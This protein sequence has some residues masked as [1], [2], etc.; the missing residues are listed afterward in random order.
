MVV[1]LAD[2]QFGKI[3]LKIE[4]FQHD[5]DISFPQVQINQRPAEFSL[6][7]PA[8]ILEINY[9][10]ARES[11]GYCGITTQ[12]RLFNADAKATSEAGIERRVQEGNQLSRIDE[13][14]SIGELVAYSLEPKERDLELVNIEPIK[15]SFRTEPLRWNIELGGVTVNVAPG[16]VQGQFKYGK[17]D[18]YLEQKPYLKFRAVGQ[19]FDMKR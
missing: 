3:G 1:L 13:K 15:I 8:A 11:L 7:Q 5:L 16:H 14:V 12:L 9:T 18:S 19:V 2:Q 10:P 6:Q 4:P 17:V